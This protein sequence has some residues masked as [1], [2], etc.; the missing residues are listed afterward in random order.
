MTMVNHSRFLNSVQFLMFKIDHNVSEAE[1]VTILKKNEIFLLGNNQ[2][3]APFYLFIYLFRVSTC[4]ERHSAH[5]Q[6]IELY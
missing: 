4:F 2:L 6:E 3:D 1:N 5:H